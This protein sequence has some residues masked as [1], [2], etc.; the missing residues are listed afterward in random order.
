MVYFKENFVFRRFQGDPTFTRGYNFFMERGWGVELLI[1]RET[2][3]LVIFKL[4]EIWT[5][6]TPLDLH[7]DQ[8]SKLKA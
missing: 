8:D 4:G 7:M 3:E 1:P 6:Y 5:P 2:Y